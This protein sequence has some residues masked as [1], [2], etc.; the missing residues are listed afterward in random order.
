MSLTYFGKDFGK[1][2]ITPYF[3]S[4][5]NPLRA[6]LLQKS[7][8]VYVRSMSLGAG[9]N[10]IVLAAIRANLT[11]TNNYYSNQIESQGTHPVDIERA[12]RADFSAQT[13]QQL[14]QKLAL[15]YA[16]AQQQ[17]FAF[18]TSPQCPNLFSI[19]AIQT[20]HKAL[21]GSK[22]LPPEFLLIKDHAG[23]IQLTMQPGL[24]RDRDVKVGSHIAPSATELSRLLNQFAQHYAFNQIE[25]ATQKIFKT[26]IAHHRFMYLHPFLDG[27]GRVG[28]LM[29]DAALAQIDPSGHGLWSLSRGLAR[30]KADYYRLLAQADNVRRG[31]LDGRGQLTES[32]LVAFVDF[33]LEV[34][35]DQIAFM[36]QTLKLDGLETR[37]QGHLKL[38][39]M[40]MVN[41]P[42][43][44]KETA[45]LIPH[46]LIHGE[47]TKSHLAGLLGV[48]ERK[49]RT[50]AGELKQRGLVTEVNQKSP[51]QIHFTSQMMAVLFPDII[52]R[53]SSS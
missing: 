39:E 38:C 10:P 45:K 47:I 23:Q 35:L 3:P 11:M 49:A 53:Y 5:A 17:V 36:A 19:E 1:M 27:N 2:T 20:I 13:E 7:E 52:P 9:L 21:Y 32:G 28:R 50:I 41:E 33:M 42:P 4:E 43:Y 40:A 18:A 48:S 46:L 31:D 16:D 34:A 15:A 12:M 14:M 51:L 30:N 8:Q 25:L 22:H 44:P 29:M 24:V 6:R 26:V 37:L